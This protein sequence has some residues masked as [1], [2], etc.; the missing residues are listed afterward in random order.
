MAAAGFGHIAA[1]FR[2]PDFRTFMI[3][4]VGNHMG[5]WTLRMT[6]GWLAWQL[7][8]S[9]TWLGLVGFADLAPVMIV[10]PLSGVLVDRADR[11]AVLRWAQVVIALLTILLFFL[12]LNGLIFIELLFGLL[13]LIGVFL[14]IAQPARTAIIPGLVD[15]RSLLA[16]ISINALVS[17]GGRLVGPTV[18]GFVIVHYG[19]AAAFAFCAGAFIFFVV[20]LW[21]VRIRSIDHKPKQRAGIVAEV[22]E[23]ATYA[24][25]HPGIGPLMVTMTVTALVGRSFSTLFPGFAEAVFD[26][27][28]DALAVLTAVQGAGAMIGGVYL[29]RRAGISGLTR[30]FALNVAAIGFGLIAFG[31]S[32]IYPLAVVIVAAMGSSLLI[33]ST[34]AQTLMQHAVEEDKRGRISGLY[35]FIQ[36]GGQAMGALLLGVSGDLIGLRGTIIAAGVLCLCFWLWSLPRSKAMAKALEGEGG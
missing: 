35:G 24:A 6:A 7:T 36:R 25:R 28:A 29:A 34:S 13:L 20:M 1:A 33:N 16:A 17:N 19:I 32:D 18:G 11:L 10:G 12:V 21:F 15:S 31:S 27:G 26:R 9:A 4:N 5:M 30:V 22:V 14:S 3:G 2:Q 23:G 8:E